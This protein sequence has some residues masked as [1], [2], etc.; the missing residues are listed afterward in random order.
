MLGQLA[1]AH[2]F[3]DPDHGAIALKKY[4]LRCPG[5][6]CCTKR[7]AR[8]SGNRTSTRKTFALGAG[9]VVGFDVTRALSFALRFWRLGGVV[10]F[11]LTI[12]K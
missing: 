2:C 12:Y 7:L 9:G 4:L 5:L 1:R 8:S 11:V 10:G 3:H 6:T